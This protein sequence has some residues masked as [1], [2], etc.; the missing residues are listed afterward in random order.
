MLNSSHIN[1]MLL[2]NKPESI[3]S[4]EVINKIKK[5]FSIK[6]IGHSGTLDKFASGLLILGINEGTK[7]LNYLIDKDK[8]YDAVFELG[9]TTDTLDITGKIE[10]ICSSTEP[11]FEKIKNVIEQFIGE[12]YQIPPKYS[13]IKVGGRRSSDLIREGKETKLMPRLVNIYNIDIKSYQYPYLNLIIECSKGTYIRSL[14]RDIGEKLETGAYVKKLIRT[15]IPPYTL[16]DS[17]SLDKLLVMEN[18]SKVIVKLSEFIRF[19][20]QIFIDDI[21]KSLL[22]R[23][24]PIPAKVSATGKYFA[25][26][27]K[28]KLFAIL[29]IDVEKNKLCLKTDRL[30]FDN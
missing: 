20:P 1:G 30:I 8:I 3:T 15:E 6:K 10:N 19:M 16:E 2:I 18:I 26:L 23:G 7:I 25:G 21:E 29:R 28:G 12:Q 24:K 13:A 5:K 22:E 17:I 14:A 4:S 9:K 27:Y 11:T